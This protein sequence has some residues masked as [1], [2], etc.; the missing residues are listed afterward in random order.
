MLKQ[1]RLLAANLIAP[2][3]L[4]LVFGI[5]ASAQTPK[6]G[7]K[8]RRPP[9]LAARRAVVLTTDCG[10]DM[11]DQWTLAQLALAPELELRGVVTTHAPSLAA[12]AADTA[13]RVSNEVF[14]HL[15]LKT[16]PPSSPVPACR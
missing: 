14:D 15:P 5:A 1:K 10:A 7:R 9:T 13:A 2:L 16:R 8:G 6:T 4:T 11:D 12:P 3:L